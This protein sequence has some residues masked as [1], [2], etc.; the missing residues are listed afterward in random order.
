MRSY[1][2]GQPTRRDAGS[3]PDSNAQILRHPRLRR[4]L[5]HHL[6]RWMA[7]P[8]RWTYRPTLAAWPASTSAQPRVALDPRSRTGAARNTRRSL[9]RAILVDV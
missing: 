5:V 3:L 6:I 7:P 9:G 8:V 1:G 4:P 2:W